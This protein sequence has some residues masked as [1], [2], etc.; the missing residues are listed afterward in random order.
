MNPEVSSPQ[1]EVEELV[2]GHL[3]EAKLVAITDRS[4]LSSVQLLEMK[5]DTRKTSLGTLGKLLPGL[6]HL[7]LNNSYIP[8]IRDIGSGYLNLTVLWM[9]RCDMTDLDGIDSMSNL[10]E[11]YLAHNE[12]ADISALGMLENLQVLDLEGNA[13]ESMEQIEYLA[14]CLSL[15]QLTVTNNP[16]RLESD[17]NESADDEWG[18]EPRKWAM[19]QRELRW[20][21]CSALPG[22]KILN[23]VRIIEADRRKP[24]VEQVPEHEG[25]T[26]LLKERPTASKT[27][28]PRTSTGRPSSASKTSHTRT[29]DV[30]S[31]LTH[32]SGQIMAG[33]PVLYL[34]SR[35]TRIASRESGLARASLTAGT[36]DSISRAHEEATAGKGHTVTD[37]DAD[38]TDLQMPASD[39][40]ST[41]LA[42]VE[43]S[44]ASQLSD[45]TR[46]EPPVTPTLPANA[47]SAPKHPHP[48]IAPPTRNPPRTP[49]ARPSTA[50]PT[51]SASMKF[52]L[53][54]YRSISSTDEAHRDFSGPPHPAHRNTNSAVDKTTAKEPWLCWDGPIVTEPIAHQPSEPLRPRPPARPRKVGQGHDASATDRADIQGDASRG[55][56][57][58]HFYARVSSDVVWTRRRPVGMPGLGRRPETTMI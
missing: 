6:R 44:R 38:D 54:R 36:V 27:R 39:S 7:K 53:H 57:D 43:P 33:N 4:D 35:R 25:V 19:R 47:P 17:P 31:D 56:K 10:E 15:R 1:D 42:A 16:I 29:E 49:S 45:G 26:E 5:V 12:I 2:K 40:T 11:L 21:L 23:D 14:L 51:M 22:L 46:S 20:N 24:E 18:V 8:S 52:R 58:V 50:E 34:R 3:S 9:A 30:T 55:H 13:I 32:G 28:R 48:P 41:R 37:F